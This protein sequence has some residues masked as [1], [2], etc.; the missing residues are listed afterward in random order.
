VP[1]T[2][3]TLG[4]VGSV[5]SNGLFTATALGHGA[6]IATYSSGNTSV[7]GAAHVQVSNFTAPPPGNNSTSYSLFIVPPNATLNIGGTQQF[8][9]YESLPNGSLQQVSSSLLTWATAGGIGSVGS[10]GL[11]TATSAGTGT[12][13]AIYNGPSP[14]GVANSTVTAYVTVNSSPPP[15]PPG[16][17]SYYIMVS[18]AS[19]TL[20]VG[21]TQQFVGQLYDSNGTYLYDMPNSNMIWLSNN[22]A[23]GTIDALGV[24]SAIAPGFAVVKAG[25]IGTNYTNITVQNL[26]NV[27]VV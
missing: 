8:N 1:F 4:G 18:P 24:F 12:V 23:V 7:S 20:L 15:P 21:A 13:F 9:V 19:A 26:A 2:W 17:G 25:Y 22:T 11:F 14:I 10:T 6:V 16:N 27:T 5:T 3:S